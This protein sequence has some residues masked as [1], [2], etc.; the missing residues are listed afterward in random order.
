MATP[1][2]TRGLVAR[3][4]T[5]IAIVALTAALFVIYVLRG[6]LWPFLAG[7]VIAY[8]LDPVCDRLEAARVPRGVGAALIVLVFLL[9]LSALLFVLVPVLVA[10]L[11]DLASRMPG[12]F[13]SLREFA[14]PIIRD[15]EA[16][17]SG[18]LAQRLRDALTDVSGDRLVGWV[19]SAL[20]G[21]LSGGI[22][23]I[24]LLSI[25]VIMPV[26]AF[27]LLRDWDKI[28]AH[29]MDLVPRHMADTVRT[30]VREIDGR[31]SGFIRGQGMVCAILGLFYAVGLVAVGLDFG[32]V[33]GLGAG[34]IS[35]IPYVGTVVGLGSGLGLAFAQFSDWLPIVGVACVFAAGQAL[36]D[37]VLVPKLI[38]DR[39]G[40]HPAWVLFA[41]M[42]GGTVFGFTGV[43]L[44]VPAAAVIGVLVR[45]AIDRYK[46]SDLYRDK[47]SDANKA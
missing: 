40:L 23:L 33:V 22:A 10:Q 15:M 34:L 26:V 9:A 39:V 32:L 2:A 29:V 21:A 13:E 46:A 7:M 44:A 8:L 1:E 25:L 11:A 3:N 38:G 27:Y 12:Y 31:L 30:L 6:A 41:L 47:S 17:I 18:D 19:T 42:A 16:K 36:Q 37:F 35:F 45:F 43:L 14:A 5:L 4:P 28:V 20:S 24:T